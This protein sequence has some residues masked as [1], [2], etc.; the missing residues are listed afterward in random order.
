MFK[1]LSF[2]V[3]FTSVSIACEDIHVKPENYSAKEHKECG[4][5]VINN[6][7]QKRCQKLDGVFVKVKNSK[8]QFCS[9]LPQPKDGK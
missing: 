3:A 4:L 5:V 9:V 2:L 8:E 6:M 1:V 7:S